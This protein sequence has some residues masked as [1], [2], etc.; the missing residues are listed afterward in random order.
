VLATALARIVDSRGR[1]LVP[2]LRPPEIPDNVRQVLTDI[3]VGGG[4]ST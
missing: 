2:G 1:I 3:A 4:P